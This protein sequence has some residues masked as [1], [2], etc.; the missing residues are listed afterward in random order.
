MF[1]FLTLLPKGHQ[2][3]V[4]HV[5]VLNETPAA[6]VKDLLLNLES[7]PRYSGFADFGLNILPFSDRTSNISLACYV[8]V[9]SGGEV[10]PCVDLLEIVMEAIVEAKPEW[11]VRWSTCK[12]GRS[13]RCLSCRLLDLYPGV[14]DRTAITPDHLLLIKAHIEKK[15]FKIGSIFVS[16]GDPQITFLL[17]SDADRFNALQFIEVPAKVSM[18]HAH[19]ELLKEFPILRPFELVV[20]GAWDFDHLEGILEKWIKKTVSHSLINI[21]TTPLN[22][23]LIIFTMSMWTDTVKVLCSADSFQH[24]FRNQLSMLCLLGTTTMTAQQE[25]AWRPGCERCIPDQWECGVT[26]SSIPRA[27]R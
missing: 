7:E 24:H 22:T 13:D 14:T 18:G 9:L 3:V 4:P 20:L 17:S 27:S 26:I 15:G 2:L 6:A 1:F 19:I 16:F 8:E 23:D 10:E 21:R 5:S 25:L 11:K 12:K